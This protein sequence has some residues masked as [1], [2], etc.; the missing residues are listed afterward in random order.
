M[1]FEFGN[2][3]VPAVLLDRQ[4][5]VTAFRPGTTARSDAPRLSVG[6]LMGEGLAAGPAAALAAAGAVAQQLGAFRGALTLPETHG[7]GQWDCLWYPSEQGSVALF[8]GRVPTPAAERRSQRDERNLDEAWRQAHELAQPLATAEAAAAAL[9]L[10][11]SD[12]QCQ[13]AMAQLRAAVARAGEL[14]R[15]LRRQATMPLAPAYA[16]D[17]VAEIHTALADLAVPR[18][19]SFR[20]PAQVP[21][22]AAAKHVVELIVLNLVRNA[23]S[24]ADADERQVT[25]ELA[26][27]EEGLE[28]I[29]ADNGPGIPAELVPRLFAPVGKHGIA[30]MGLAIARRLAEL[31]GGSLRLVANEPGKRTAFA[32]VLPAAAMASAA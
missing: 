15:M 5:R 6:R 18:Q 32:A 22:V 2:V 20:P 7:A 3:P 10:L 23:L 1:N 31:H 19:V 29:V 12:A 25:V 26:A 16:I 28:I 4:L 24:A 27:H 17:P 8:L 9:G 30:G 21:E 11:N 14:L 13:P